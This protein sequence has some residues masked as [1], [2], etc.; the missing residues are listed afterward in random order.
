L[1]GVGIEGIQVEAGYH[2]VRET[3][4]SGASPCDQEWNHGSTSG[5]GKPR[6]EARLCG[7]V[8]DPAGKRVNGFEP[9]TFTLATCKHTALPPLSGLVSCCDGKGV[10]D[11]VTIPAHDARLKR[12]IEA[13][14]SL[15][16]GVKDAIVGL[17]EGK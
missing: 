7:M 14:S 5:N 6:H 10:T 17:V 16:V 8:L 15:P 11:T 9:S 3:V 4:Q 12:L 1:F 13:W 2:S